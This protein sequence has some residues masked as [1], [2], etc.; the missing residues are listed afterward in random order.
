MLR[1]G[2]RRARRIRA[3]KNG[4]D[5][6]FRDYVYK[7]LP[8][9]L[10]ELWKEITKYEN[11]KGGTAKVEALLERSG[12]PARQNIFIHAL[13]HSNFNASQ[14]CRKANISKTC[15]DEW[16]NNDPNFGELIDEIQ[17]HQE[18]FFESAFCRLIR[19]GDTSATIHAVKTKLRHR[20]FGDK[21]VIDINRTTTLNM[22]VIKISDL[23]LSLEI[24]KT[25][26]EAIRKRKQITSEVVEQK[27]AGQ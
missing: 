1:I 20:G 5:L 10:R 13:F 6:S 26:L 11:A 25:V 19:A 12:V 22:N 2:L 24:K 9:H 17:W 23:D 18:N 4:K 21:T 3:N 15:L 16:I 27:G 7:Q 8:G 14:A